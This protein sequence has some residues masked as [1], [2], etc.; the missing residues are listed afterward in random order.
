M[1]VCVCVDVQVK[2]LLTY[3]QSESRRAVR[4]VALRQLYQL[5]TR[6]PHTWTKEMV[7]VIE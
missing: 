1:C 3:A 7:E 4:V 6:V 5:A 2:L